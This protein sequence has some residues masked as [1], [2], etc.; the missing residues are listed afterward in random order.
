MSVRVG[1][2]TA[3]RR[4]EI[5]AFY[6][7]AFGWREMDGISNDE[8]L[9]MWIGPSSY[10]NVRERSDH[11][12]LSYEHF[13]VSVSTAEAV[14]ELWERVTELGAHPE[15]LKAEGSVPMFKFQHLLPMAIEVQYIPSNGLE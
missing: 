3:E 15:P 11:A 12:E 14:R 5:L 8:R 7:A 6:G 13:G 4:S 9:A 2:L 1:T 10:I